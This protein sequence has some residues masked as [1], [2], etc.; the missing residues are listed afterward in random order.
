MRLHCAGLLL[1]G[2][3]VM[4]GAPAAAQDL[5]RGLLAYEDGDYAAALAE[6]RPLAW[7]GNAAAQFGIGTMYEK[8]QGVPAD[9]AQAAGWYRRAAEQGAFPAQHA[10]G[11]LYAAGRGVP[12]DHASAADWYGRAAEQGYASAQL[13]I[14]ILLELGLGVPADLVE[15]FKWFDLAAAQGRDDAATFREEVA[16]QMAPAAI[17]EAEARAAAWRAAHAPPDAR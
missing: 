6:W 3:L 9:P 12:M 13:A 10:L 17:A 2:L 1:L 8:G 5:A 4:V 16:A 7:Q 11:V 15:A 14:G